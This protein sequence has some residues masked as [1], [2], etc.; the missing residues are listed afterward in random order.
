VRSSNAAAVPHD[1]FFGDDA[2]A[3][4]ADARESR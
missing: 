3:D 4:A 2:D 1:H